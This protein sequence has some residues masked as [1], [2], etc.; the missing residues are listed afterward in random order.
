MSELSAFLLNC[1]V[2]SLLLW[3]NPKESGIV[4]GSATAAFLAY[5]LNPFSASTIV[6]YAVAIASLAA[7]LWAQMGNFVSR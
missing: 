5:A 4:F 7:F 2:E 3:H 1:V 6:C